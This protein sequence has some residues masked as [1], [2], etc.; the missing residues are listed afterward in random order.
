[1]SSDNSNPGTG[2]GAGAV[3]GIGHIGHVGLIRHIGLIGHI[4]GVCGAVDAAGA[5]GSDVGNIGSGSGSDLDLER[6]A[7]RLGTALASRGWHV[8]AAESCT[9]GWVAK[10]ITDIAGSS[11]W[12]G[13]GW[14]TYSNTA[15]T[16][17]L[18]VPAE[19]IE[20]QGAVSEAVVRAMADAARRQSGAEL[21]VAVSGV[22]GPGGGTAAKPVGLV[23][24]AWAGP[25]RIDAE[26]HRF[27]GDREAVRRQSVAHALRGLIERAG[28]GN[29]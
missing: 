5:D 29:P 18:G 16:K 19:I 14:V 8:A 26:S 11:E 24:F 27:D 20:A 3:A 6:L 21:A 7:H 13:A 10:T 22:A 15:K 2:A 12:F 1:M 4:A 9:G 17:L 28:G 25:E 23:W